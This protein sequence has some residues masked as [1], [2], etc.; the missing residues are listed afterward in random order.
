MVK[1]QLNL[2]FPIC[3]P[4]KQKGVVLIVSLVFLIA[5]TAVAAAMM[6]NTSTDMKMAGASQEKLIATQETLSEMDEIIHN[7]VRKVDG[8]NNFTS[9]LPLFP[10]NPTVNEPGIT[11]ATI[12]IVNP[13]NLIADCPHTGSASSV[14]VFKCNVLNVTVSRKY[15]RTNNSTVLVNAG[16]AQQL[17]N[18]TN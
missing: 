9:A 6:Q 5:L 12:A 8:T 17:I 4:K 1:R 18:G 16:I 10:I 14:Q 3:Q 11:T 2:F 15:G 7:Q 13:L